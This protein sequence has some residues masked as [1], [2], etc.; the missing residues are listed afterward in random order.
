LL[1][2]QAKLKIILCQ[3]LLHTPVS[4]KAI[5]V[6]P[7]ELVVYQFS[8]IKL[9]EVYRMTQQLEKTWAG[10]VLSQEEL[11]QYASTVSI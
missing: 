11:K 10:K 7:V 8:I 3:N 6:S 1:A 5:G 4:L 2:H 9:I